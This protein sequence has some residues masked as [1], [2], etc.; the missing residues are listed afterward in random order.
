MNYINFFLFTKQGVKQR[1]RLSSAPILG[2]NSFVEGGGRLWGPFRQPLLFC[3]RSIDNGPFAKT[4]WLVSRTRRVT[5]TGP[6]CTRS[7]ITYW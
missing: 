2:R 5:E 7:T 3:A 6:L 4:K 1:C